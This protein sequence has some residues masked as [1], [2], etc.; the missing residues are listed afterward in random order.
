MHTVIKATDDRSALCLAIVVTLF[1]T[2]SEASDTL[3]CMNPRDGTILNAFSIPRNCDGVTSMRG[4]L[5]KKYAFFNQ[6]VASS[7]RFHQ[8]Y[9]IRTAVLALFVHFICTYSACPPPTVSNQCFRCTAELKE[10]LQLAPEGSGRAHEFDFSPQPN[11]CTYSVA[12]ITAPSRYVQTTDFSAPRA[13][14]L[15]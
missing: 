15:L 6:Y 9:K 14:C 7:H 4:V 12:I 13:R 3:H 10:A 1:F 5:Y 11:P 2:G 8:I